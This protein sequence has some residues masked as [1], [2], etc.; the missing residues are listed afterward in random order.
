MTGKTLSAKEIPQA[1]VAEALFWLVAFFAYVLWLSSYWATYG[2]VPLSDP[3]EYPQLA[4]AAHMFYDSGLRE[5]LYIGF[6]K[7]LLPFVQ[8]DQFALRTGSFYATLGA[9]VLLVA[10][11][12]LQFGLI[13]A[14]AAGVALALSEPVGYYALQGNN[15]VA[16]S[17]MVVVFLVVWMNADRWKGGFLLAGMVGGL[18]ALTRLEGI[19]VVGLCFLYDAIRLIRTKDVWKPVAAVVLATALLSPWLI[20]QKATTGGFL[21]SHTVH[22]NYLLTRQSENTGAPVEEGG[23]WG[24]F[25]LSGGVST[26]V[27]RWAY[28][29][30][31]GFFFY[32]PGLWKAR[33]WL[34]AF[35]AIALAIQFRKKDFRHLV[36]LAAIL[37]PVA[38]ILP[39][40][41]AFP[42]SGVEI[43]Y[44]LALAWPAALLVGIGANDVF[45]FASGFR[46]R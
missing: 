28:G 19:A 16:Y 5:P 27:L 32:L 20:W 10:W 13:A 41:Q 1:I 33:S 38:Y 26:L 18:V 4:R 9:G 36:A 45:Q 46:R 7:L 39:M 14:A 22:A 23:T 21:T 37:F 34:L 35:A 15:M 2:R 43:R 6:I 17:L 24:R 30:V 8:P 31:L 25:F 44:V 3:L 29:Y 12:R 42:G 40:D 11:A